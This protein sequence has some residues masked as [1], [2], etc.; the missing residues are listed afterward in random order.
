MVFFFPVFS[1]VNFENV[2]VGKKQWNGNCYVLNLEAIL[3][4]FKQWFPNVFA[5]V[6]LDQ[7]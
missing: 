4:S 3:A 5:H 2:S 7:L 6:P 1:Y